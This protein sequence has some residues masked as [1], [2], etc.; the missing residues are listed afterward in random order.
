[1]CELSVEFWRDALNA[2]VENFQAAVV[3]VGFWPTMVHRVK[4]DYV[5]DS[6]RAPREL[7]LKCARPDWEGDPFG[8][9]REYRVYDELLSRIQVAQPQR[10]HTALDSS[11]HHCQIV[12]EDLSAQYT[13]YPETHAWTWDE[14]RAMLRTY[15]RIHAAALGFHVERLPYLMPRLCERWAPPRARKMFADFLDTPW[16]A[17]RA[18]PARSAVERVLEELPVLEKLAGREPLTLVHYDAYPP[19]I[20]F[21]RHTSSV[22]QT[23][24]L[25]ETSFLP[26]SDEMQA[27][28]IDWALAT[29]DI[30]EVDLAFIFQQ[31]YHSD[32]LVN[33]RDA[34]QYYWN[35]Q[36]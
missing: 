29:R 2:P 33:W 8:Q 6:S 1:M 9:Q 23:T 14:V 25:G 36:V 15:A 20:G 26:D 28:I 34:L 4:L 12:M 5:A 27:V 31:P 21:M 13:F 11:D 18:Q 19:N 24:P 3:K 16:L 30:A 35:E 22:Q 17:P 32:C 7:V 10:Y